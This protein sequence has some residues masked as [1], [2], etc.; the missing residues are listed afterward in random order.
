MTQIRA[1]EYEGGALARPRESAS[2]AV[3]FD[4]LRSR[5]TE[6]HSQ[7]D[8]IMQFSVY[9]PRSTLFLDDSVPPGEAAGEAH[10]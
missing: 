6:E 5:V 2:S 7:P 1:D 3:K 8:S 10:S 4:F 9:L